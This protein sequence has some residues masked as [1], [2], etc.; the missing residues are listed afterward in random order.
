MRARCSERN[1][2]TRAS[3]R[4]TDAISTY[5]TE[6]FVRVYELGICVRIYRSS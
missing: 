4:L 1:Y 6:V 3:N 2:I 5:S